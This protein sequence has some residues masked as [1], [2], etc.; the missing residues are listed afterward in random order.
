[1]LRENSITDRK[2]NLLIN[3]LIIMIKDEKM[4]ISERGDIEIQQQW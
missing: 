1:M 2:A 3:P 4:I